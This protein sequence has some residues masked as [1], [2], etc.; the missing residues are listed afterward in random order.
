[1]ISETRLQKIAKNIIVKSMYVKEKEAV[2]ISAGSNSLNFAEKLAYEAAM[3][4]ANPII[5]YSSN[6][7]SL[8]IYKDIKTKYLKRIPKLS[9]T[10]AEKVD[11]QIFLDDSNPFLEKKLPQ[12]KVQTRNIAMKPIR[13][14]IDRRIVNKTV[15]RVLVGFPNKATA[16]SLGISYR[17]LS[18]I[19]W[20]TLSMDPYKLFKR[21]EKIMKKL[22]NADKIHIV[23]KKTDLEFSVKGREP[24]NDCGLWTKDKLGYLN[25]PA[26]E[27][28]Y[29]PVETSAN[30]EIY[31]DMPCLWHFGKQV[32]G[33]WFK[34]K[35]G[36]VVDYKIKKGLKNFEDVMKHATGDKYR[37]AE[38]GIGTNPKAK[39]TGGMTIVDEK[40]TKTIHLAIGWNKGYGGKNDSTI[41]WDFF[42][43][44]KR[45]KM[46]V[47][48]KLFMKNG[49]II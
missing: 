7:L 25:L 41:H 42:K 21:N 1:M 31:F 43:N 27:V 48:D 32:K 14:I 2:V 39:P 4:G 47:D 18:N 20:S 13:K 35:K 22:K 12:K 36:K 40:L 38:L 8:K 34:F 9:K 24:I 28:F 46:F 49:K 45:G 19:F 17:K 30:G 10:F 5:N 11:V 37:L 6:K 3:I 26:G 44:M 23:G 33:V 29:A 15:K 16:K